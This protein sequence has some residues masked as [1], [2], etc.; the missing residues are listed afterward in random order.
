MPPRLALNR[1]EIPM[2][3]TAHP[4]PALGRGRPAL[5]LV[6]I[7]SFIA[8][9]HWWVLTHQEMF[10]KLFLFLF[11]FAGLSAGGVVYPP[12]FY[13]LTKYGAHL[14]KSMK[15]LG[16]ICAAAGFA[17]GFYLMLVTYERKF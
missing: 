1:Y 16:A 5:S 6:L 4:S 3:T 9:H 13:A 12:A 17:L 10:P 11:T 15:V 14:P 8:V 2:A 7:V